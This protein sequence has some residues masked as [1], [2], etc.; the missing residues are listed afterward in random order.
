MKTYSAIILGVVVV[1][2]LA[3][4]CSDDSSNESPRADLNLEPDL[5]WIF[6]NATSTDE[7]E[8]NFNATGSSD[9]DGEIS[10]YHYEYGEGNYSDLGGASDKYTYTQGG[11]YIT[12]LT[13]EDG[14]GDEDSV[15]QPLTINYQYYREGQVLDAT[16]GTSASDHPFAVSSFNPD[17]GEVEVVINALDT[18]SPPT[19]DVT[20][21]NAEDEEVAHAQEENIQ[22]NVTITIPLDRQD[23]NA[24]GY[25]QWR[26]EVECENGSIEYDITVQVLYW[27]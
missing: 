10:N 16:T 13:V 8:I 15:E 12:E 1:S 22:G 21:Y 20:V 27:R 3:M 19:V 17:T 9:P 18:G 14:E 25:G 24:Y 5:A 23:F 7:P 2:L 26:V 4:G 6:D 11:Y